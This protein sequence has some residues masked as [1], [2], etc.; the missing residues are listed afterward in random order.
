MM[1]YDKRAATARNT[2]VG[3]AVSVK[4]ETAS[5]HWLWYHTFTATNRP[6]HGC[7]GQLLG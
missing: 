3:V 2:T 6:L 4:D 5:L 1:K 7:R